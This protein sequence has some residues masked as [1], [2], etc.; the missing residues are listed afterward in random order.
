TC[1]VNLN[2]K[3]DQFT[4]TATLDWKVTSDL[5]LYVAHRKGYRAGGLSTRAACSA[6][7]VYFK[8]E[9]VKDYEIGAKLN[10]NLGSGIFLQTNVAAY[11]QDYKD[12]QR[13]VPLLIEG[14]A[15]S[16]NIVNAASAEI[17]GF[18]VETTFAV[19]DW[20]ELGGF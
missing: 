16:T 20:L 17:K 19:A 15:I 12:I 13:L 7:L 1:L 6:E 8:P 4:Y 2:E 14:G 11:K 18:E 3:F 9:E 10:L 5:L